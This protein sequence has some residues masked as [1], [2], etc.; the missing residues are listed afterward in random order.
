[1]H[2]YYQG[3]QHLGTCSH[4]FRIS[5]S[6]VG[7]DLKEDHGRDGWAISS[8]ILKDPRSVKHLEGKE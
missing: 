6:R 7:K 1:M 3:H 5:G 2:Y 8:N 4:Q